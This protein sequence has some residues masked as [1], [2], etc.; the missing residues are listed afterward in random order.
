MSSDR[1]RIGSL[2]HVG[3]V[4][5]DLEAAKRLFVETLGCELDSETYLD[6]LGLNVAFVGAGRVQIELIEPTREPERR[7]RLGTGAARIEHLAFEVDDLDAAAA[8]MS[9]DGVTMVGGI[10][11]EAVVGEVLELKT[12]RNVFSL[13]ATS[14]D[15]LFQ[16]SEL[17]SDG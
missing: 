4:V 3:I 11:P 5:A 12:G 17:S 14:L 7:E 10:G 9:D 13:P 6:S 15:L 8:T 1:D 2:H 16:L